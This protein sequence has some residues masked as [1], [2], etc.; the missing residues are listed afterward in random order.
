MTK[1]AITQVD[2]LQAARRAILEHIARYRL[3]TFAAVRK[4]P[5]IAHWSVGEIRQVLRE[6]RQQGLIG[7]ASLHAASRYWHLQPPGATICGLPADRSGPL[8]E[9][10]KFRAYALLRFCCLSGEIRHRLLHG[11]LAMHFQELD[12]PGLPSGYY[13]TGSDRERIGFARIDTSHFGHWK[14]VA[15]RFQQDALNH[16]DRPTFRQLTQGGRF[17]LTLVT[18]LPQKA[19]RLTESLRSM[20]GDASLSARVVAIPELLPLIH[21]RR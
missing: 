2:V 4:L 21:I 20:L 9:P 5:A 11:E 16:L 6:S 17:E 8:S 3:T 15:R 13:V 18:V 1:D 7:T 14:R 12:R 10:S 19:R